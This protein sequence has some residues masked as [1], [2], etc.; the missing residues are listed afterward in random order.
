[1]NYPSFGIILKDDFEI[2]RSAS[3]SSWSQNDGIRG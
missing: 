3:L 2:L 1:M